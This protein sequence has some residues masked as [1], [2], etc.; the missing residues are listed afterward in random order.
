MIIDFHTHIFPPQIRAERSLFFNGEPA[1]KLLYDSPKARLA[2]AAELVAALDEHGIDKAVTFGFHWHSAEYYK[3]HNDYIMEATARYPERLVGLGC[4]DSLHPAAAAETERCLSSG[5]AGMGELAFYCSDLD[6][7]SLDRLESIMAICRQYDR[8]V[9]L[10][11]NEP[12]GHH[13]PGK[14]ENSL[15]QIYALVQRFY[16]NRI[17]LA[18]WGAGLFFYKLLRKEVTET[19]SNVWF[20]T[21]A[22]PYLYRPEVYSVAVRLAG[23][24]KI[25][26]GS[27]Y[28]LL[29]A[30]RYFDE[31]ARAGLADDEQ[32]LIGGDNAAALLKLRPS[33]ESR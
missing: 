29:S 21:A 27:D 11:T 33:R 17:V 24:E 13:Y 7:A 9:M 10:H 18:H 25:L 12:V 23:K 30:R 26:F 6:C 8:L 16:Q 15:A 20:D 4:C 28:P 32:R 14:T 5:L 22:S 31:M 3:R 2:G 19:L 1:F